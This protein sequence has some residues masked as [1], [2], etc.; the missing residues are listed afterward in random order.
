MR[1]AFRCKRTGCGWIWLSNRLPR[2]PRCPKCF[3]GKW[4]EKGPVPK[5]RGNKAKTIEG[6]MA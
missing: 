1:K 6:L 2:P 5:K 3:S 4:W